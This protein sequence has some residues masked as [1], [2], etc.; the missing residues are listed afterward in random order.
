MARS[1]EIVAKKLVEVACVNVAALA[2]RL[3]IFAFPIDDDTA[4]VVANVVVEV[5]DAPK[6]ACVAQVVYRY[7]A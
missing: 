2:K 3:P 5:K 7:Y 1:C 4:V 6:P